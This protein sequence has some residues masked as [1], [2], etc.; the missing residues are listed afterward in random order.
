MEWSLSRP[1]DVIAASPGAR[2]RF[3][4]EARVAASIEHPGVVRVLDF[5]QHG[6][7]LFLTMG[8]VR[9]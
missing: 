9:G 4:R 6:N 3:E 1:E 2:A 8:F 7:H 5:G